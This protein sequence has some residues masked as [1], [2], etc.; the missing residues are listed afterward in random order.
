MS[1]V[2]DLHSALSKHPDA[3]VAELMQAVETVTRGLFDDAEIA[4]F[5][6]RRSRQPDLLG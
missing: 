5:V 4:E 3:T 2:D 1:L 6:A